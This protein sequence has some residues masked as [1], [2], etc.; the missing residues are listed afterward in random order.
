MNTFTA[1]GKIRH[2]TNPDTIMLATR[3]GKTDIQL[4][5]VADPSTIPDQD[6]VVIIGH[7][8][9]RRVM[10]Q[11]GW[12]SQQ[13]LIADQITPTQ[14]ILSG[15]YG[16][17]GSVHPD[18]YIMISLSC[19]VKSIDVEQDYHR[20]IVLVDYY[21][22]D[23]DPSTLRLSIRSVQDKGI[24]PGDTLMTVC[25]ISSKPSGRYIHQSL[26][27]RDYAQEV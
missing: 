8:I 15:I 14:S 5:L 12:R 27:I 2:T 21:Q 9:N 24:Q 17:P 19:R 4:I 18:P 11:T 23:R 6:H 26:L 22:T 7:I 3:C 1:V 10:T 16:V 25:G 13:T 20:L